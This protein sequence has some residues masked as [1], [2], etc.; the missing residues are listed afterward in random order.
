MTKI[1]I[2]LIVSDPDL[3]DSEDG[4]GLTERAYEELSSRLAMFGEIEDIQ[5]D[6]D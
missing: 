2:E 1:I 5:K 4:T 3:L 6:E